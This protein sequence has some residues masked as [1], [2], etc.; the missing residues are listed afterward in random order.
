MTADIR[1]KKF[2]I[3]TYGCAFNQADS[4]I[5]AGQLTNLG[6]TETSI[7]NDADFVI[8][9]TCGVK[10][11]T[12]SKIIH[13]L[14]RLNKMNKKL[15]IAGCLPRIN[16]ERV[17]RSAPNAQIIIGPRSI[18]ELKTLISKQSEEQLVSIKIHK[19]SKVGVSRVI[20]RFPT[21][22]VPINEGCLG[23]CAYCAVKFA[24][25]S[26][27]S[28]DPN[29]IYAE[30]YK[31]IQQEYKD[32]W[33]TSQDCASYGYDIN[34]NLAKLIEKL[35]EINGIYR[36]RIGMFN[37]DTALPFINELIEVFKHEKIYKFVHIP[38]Q[39]GSNR[40]LKAMLRK[41]TSEKWLEIAQR[42]RTHI[43]NITISTDIIVGFP[44]ETEEDFEQTIKLIEKIKPDI[45]N[46]SKYGDRPKTLAS[47][48]KNKVE[49]SIKKRRSTELS[50]I[51]K[52]ITLQNNEKWIDWVGMG[53]VA[54][55]APKG[56]YVIRNDWYKNIIVHDSLHL[57]SFV[58]VR[59]TDATPTYL[60]GKITK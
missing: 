22:I 49:T 48:M 31:A 17:K 5:I 28:F 7:I 60:V 38:V 11:V 21:Y 23:N 16:F 47:K 50:R 14:S 6:L 26:L 59:I 43:N 19:E 4:E 58:K 3:E 52:E 32:I 2:Y 54:E 1:G 8:I 29:E 15:I 56:G 10:E 20:H 37:V 57:G 46:I 40:I 45:T 39:S 9:N 35:T 44:G 18:S 33:I 36:M 41:Y 42:F 24:R 30:V 55:I 34:T 51:V 25:G 12:E 53:L 27:H 13:R